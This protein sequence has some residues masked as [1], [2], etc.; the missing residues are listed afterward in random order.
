[1]ATY[2]SKS[3][4]KR[5]ALKD[6]GPDALPGIDFELVQV[7]DGKWAW[8]TPA[9]KPVEDDLDTVVADAPA[10]EELDPEPA[11]EAIEAA[12]Q[13]ALDAAPEPWAGPTTNFDAL[14]AVAGEPAPPK[15][16]AAKKPRGYAGA[17]LAAAEAGE[18]PWPPAAS[19]ANMTYVKRYERIGALLDA[20][21]I[22]GLEA[23]VI[24]GTNTY[25]KLERAYRDAAIAFLATAPQRLA[26]E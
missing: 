18:R 6:L 15:G 24:G 20:G 25:S 10:P 16:T 22:E 21:D 5:A 12:E 1:M 26:A 17:V 23:L 4:A 13:A 11:P 14:D 19:T 2:S 9:A 8:A 7:A 3:N